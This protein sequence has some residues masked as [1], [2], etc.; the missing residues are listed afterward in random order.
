MSEEMEFAATAGIS[1]GQSPMAFWFRILNTIVV[2]QA[3]SVVGAYIWCEQSARR[4]LSNNIRITIQTDRQLYTFAFC[5]DE[6]ATWSYIT[7][8]TQT[9]REF[10]IHDDDD[11]DGSG[12]CC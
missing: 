12:G 5:L 6:C 2:D 1:V 4:L 9:E 7:G 3:L 11:D 8:G 10:Y